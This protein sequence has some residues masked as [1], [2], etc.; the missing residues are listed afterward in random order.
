[1][2]TVIV[3]KKARKDVDTKFGCSVCGKQIVK[4][5]SYHWVQTTGEPSYHIDC[6][7]P[8]EMLE[9]KKER[10]SRETAVKVEQIAA[11]VIDKIDSQVA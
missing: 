2:R 5:Q 11:D 6:E 7:I 10:V 3:I 4:G 9:S 1:M 8:A